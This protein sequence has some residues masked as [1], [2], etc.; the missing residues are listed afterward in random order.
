[1]AVMRACTTATFVAFLGLAFAGTFSACASGS[2]PEATSPEGSAD[3]PA[4]DAKTDTTEKKD[5][6]KAAGEGATAAA[7]ADATKATAP[8]AKKEPQTAADCKEMLTELTNEPPAGGVVMNNAQQAK[9]GETSSRLTPTA[10][11]LKSKRNAFRCCFDLW[12]KNNKG[13]GGKVLFVLE[14]APDGA[15][16]SSKVDQDK[17]DIKAPEVESCMS[18]VA[19]SL[20]FPKSPT[21]KLTTV[22][23]PFEFKALR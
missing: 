14:L 17:S 12:A 18:E 1:M 19:K 9:E 15:L 23:Y 11:V 3:K 8:A 6:P 7:P 5:E 4:A 20:T 16:K 2:P 22:S 10:E 13:Q 21:G